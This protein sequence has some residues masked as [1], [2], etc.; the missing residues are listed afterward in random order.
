MIWDRFE[1]EIGQVSEELKAKM[2]RT[3]G[4]ATCRPEFLPD[5]SDV[6]PPANIELEV[7]Y[8]LEGLSNNRDEYLFAIG[9]DIL[10]MSS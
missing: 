9:L 5:K 3:R 2:L 1:Y 10:P 6:G 4:V 7:S 8:F